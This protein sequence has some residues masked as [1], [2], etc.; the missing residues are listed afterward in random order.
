MKYS[1]ATT[2]GI[3]LAILSLSLG[4]YSADS[5]AVDK[6]RMLCNA[7]T[8]PAILLIMVGCLVSISTTGFFDMI[9]YGFSR[10][11]RALIPGGRRPDQ[12]YAAYKER[13]EKSR[14][15]DYSFILITGILFLVVA[16]VFMI[17]FYNVY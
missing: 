13:K 11:A 5:A 17:L 4:G 2:V 16:I 3:G 7:F 10:A 9:S 15:Q 8:I 14:F 6:Y 12:S 1:I